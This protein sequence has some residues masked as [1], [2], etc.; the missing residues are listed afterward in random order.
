MWREGVRTMFHQFA[1]V[2]VEN[3][4]TVIN[5]V[6]S[7]AL[8][9]IHEYI[10]K[11]L[12]PQHNDISTAAIKALKG[13]LGKASVRKI[14]IHYRLS[15]SLIE[16]T[17]AQFNLFEV[18]SNESKPP[19]YADFLQI[20]NTLFPSKPMIGYFGNTIQDETEYKKEIARR[21]VLNY[22]S[23]K[24]TQ[25]SLPKSLSDLETFANQGV[26]RLVPTYFIVDREELKILCRDLA[27][28]HNRSLFSVFFNTEDEKKNEVQR[29]E[30]AIKES[31][32]RRCAAEFE[33]YQPLYFGE[34]S[35]ANTLF[36]NP[37]HSMSN[38]HLE[39]RIFLIFMSI[40]VF[41]ITFIKRTLLQ[42][43]SE[44]LSELTNLYQMINRLISKIAQFYQ[45]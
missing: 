2:D 12:D 39:S 18:C 21:K 10:F 3:D 31:A 28:S 37:I 1:S 43:P 33:H 17:D 27:I 24:R 35:E 36:P 4:I 41:G 32:V 11:V 15:K 23:E 40:M 5:R 16:S 38:F 9:N 44:L 22:F 26:E 34:F 30:A 8:I 13:L 29:V 7:P 19:S 25:P 45:N 20:W 42:L 6:R 14:L